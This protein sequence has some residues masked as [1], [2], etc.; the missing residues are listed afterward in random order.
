MLLWCCCW[1]SLHVVLGDD[2]CDGVRDV[3][4]HG[5]YPPPCVRV[6]VVLRPLCS[7]VSFAEI[8]LDSLEVLYDLFEF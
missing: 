8:V 4:I 3:R 5:T 6:T 2:L 7:A 1:C